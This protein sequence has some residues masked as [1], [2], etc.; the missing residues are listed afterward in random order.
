MYNPDGENDGATSL[1]EA[2]KKLLG[3][4]V[5]RTAMRKS[6]RSEAERWGWRGATKQ[7]K[8]YYEDVLNKQESNVAAWY[9]AAWGGGVGE[10]K[11]WFQTVFGH[12]SPALRCE[13][14]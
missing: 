14:E 7:L 8:N 13:T 12:V 5:D 4:A 1:I 10:S 9:Q 11:D 6:A 3:N 2:T